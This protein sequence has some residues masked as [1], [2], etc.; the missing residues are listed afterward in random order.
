MRRPGGR[1][2]TLVNWLL[3][4]GA[5]TLAALFMIGHQSLT[6]TLARNS[7]TF[8]RALVWHLTSTY[9][10]FAVMPLILWLVKKFPFEGPRFYRN[11]L[12][13]AACG[14]CIVLALLAYDAAVQPALGFHVGRP[15]ESYREAYRFFFVTQFPWNVSIYC[16]VLGISAG[17]LYY[18]KFRER[19]LAAAQLQARLAQARMHVLKMQLRPHFLFNTHNAISELIYKDPEAADHMLMNLSEMLRMSLE[20][21]EVEEVPLRHELDFLG[22]YLET[23]QTRFQDRLRVRLDIADEAYEAMVPNMIL[24]PLV[25]NAVRHGIAP[26]ARGGTIEVRAAREKH[27]LRL[28]VS[29]DG[30]GH[31]SWDG[32]EVA[33]GIG[34][35]NTR[36]RLQHLYGDEHNFEISRAAGGV[37]FR[38]TLVI[39]FR[40]EGG[41]ISEWR[42]RNV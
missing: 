31:P 19:E 7:A 26:S 9:S 25:E 33:E 14:L 27:C 4:L 41:P 3:I 18:R 39:P 24:Q 12:V 11:L 15:F 1:N 13:H 20:N 17:F 23:E 2:R 22:K 35:S 21:L 29:D 34:L 8:W 32:A 10:W 42:Q 30:I 37:G 38:V 16:T 5:W 28:L 6:G 36:A 40:M